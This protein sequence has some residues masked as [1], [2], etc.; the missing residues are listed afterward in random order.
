M[1]APAVSISAPPESTQLRARILR[2]ARRDFFRQGYSREIAT[3]SVRSPDGR[4]AVVAGDGLLTLVTPRSSR[5]LQVAAMRG[6]S[7]VVWSPDAMAFAVNWTDGGAVGTWLS[8]VFVIEDDDVA[9]HLY[10]RDMV[11]PH[12]DGFTRCDEPEGANVALAGWLAG[13]REMLVVA[14]VP[15]HSSCRNM[16]EQ[17]GLRIDLATGRILEQMTERELWSR[18]R[19][20]LVVPGGE[21][22]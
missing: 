21:E 1:P 5:E 11:L 9:R 13:G 7:E 12:L 20:L 8:D 22:E 19:P 16:G 10:I 2:Q 18:Y 14:Q 4:Y 3:E 17:R 6:L 15:P